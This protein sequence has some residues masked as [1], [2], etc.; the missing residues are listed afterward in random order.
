MKIQVDTPA[1][2]QRIV[3]ISQLRA[4]TPY[5][6]GCILHFPREDLICKNRMCEVH[7][8]ERTTGKKTDVTVYP[9][10]Q[11]LEEGGTSIELVRI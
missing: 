11:E 1:G 5:P 9:S 8:E 10:I 6:D 3:D 4:Y 7:N 2:R